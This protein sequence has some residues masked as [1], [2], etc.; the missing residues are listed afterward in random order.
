MAFKKATASPYPGGESPHVAKGPFFIF[1]VMMPAFLLLIFMLL[2]VMQYK[3]L[4]SFIADKPMH[5]VVVPESAAT[6][7]QVRGKVKQFFAVSG[8][9]SKAGAETL[10]I[11]TE[12][13][14][15]LTRSS[16]S[17]SDL[18]LDY[19]L[20]L[21]DTLLVARNSLPV[22]S[23]RGTL[24]AMAK[25]LKMKGYLNSEMKGYPEFKDGKI[26]LVPTAAVMNGQPAP[27]S[28]LESKGR[29]DLREWVA[30]K[31]F[32]DKAIANL[33]EV[34]IHDDQLLL[35]KKR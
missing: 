19:H 29:I 23:L 15:H 33:A 16:R 32:Y 21:E 14:N 31:E 28:V 20:G 17:L 24:A 13:V 22:T 4:R 34:K 3:Q 30:D 9:I 25:I 10:S 6:Q 2:V 27:I 7:E 35:I 5:M 26:I 12:E 11:S 8:E 1:L 18:K